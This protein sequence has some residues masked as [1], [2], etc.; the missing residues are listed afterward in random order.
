MQLHAWDH[1]CTE[2]IVHF[3][4]LSLSAVFKTESYCFCVHKYFANKADSHSEFS[5]FEIICF[6]KK[7]LKEFQLRKWNEKQ[8]MSVICWLI[9]PWATQQIFVAH[10]GQMV[11]WGKDKERFMITKCRN[12]TWVTH[13]S[14]H[15][16][17]EC[18]FHCFACTVQWSEQ[19]EDLASVWCVSLIVRKISSCL[20]C[21]EYN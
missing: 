17:S 19:G 10:A 1:F 12:I 14:N 7:N 20:K 3:C 6:S 2:L 21:S 11:F 15:S 8:F 5:L 18:L 13:Q 16:L 4:F 9:K